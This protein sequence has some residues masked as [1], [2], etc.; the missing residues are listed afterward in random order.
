[1]GGG[2]L[3]FNNCVSRSGSESDLV[4]HLVASSSKCA[5]SSIPVYYGQNPIV[6]DIMRPVAFGIMIRR[7]GMG[8][9]AEVIG[10]VTIGEETFLIDVLMSVEDPKWSQEKGFF[11]VKPVCAHSLKKE[12]YENVV[13]FETDK[14]IASNGGTSPIDNVIGNLVKIAFNHEF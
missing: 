7:W 1:M 10:K 3:K 14:L 12:K 2:G 6:E 4:V 8:L 13:T 9:C 5:T 11:R